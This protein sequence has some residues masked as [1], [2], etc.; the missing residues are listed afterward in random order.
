MILSSYLLGIK[1]F[2]IDVLLSRI[3]LNLEFPKNFKKHT[4]KQKFIS[5]WIQSQKRELHFKVPGVYDIQFSK[6]GQYLTIVFK[7]HFKIYNT[8]TWKLEKT[9]CHNSRIFKVFMKSSTDYKFIDIYGRTHNCGYRFNLSLEN[10]ECI[11]HPDKTMFVVAD[12]NHF[13]VYS[14]KT[15]FITRKIIKSRSPK[16]FFSPC[17]SWFFCTALFSPTRMYSTTTWEDWQI[18]EKHIQEDSE[19]SESSVL[20][21]STRRNWEY[22]I[23][24]N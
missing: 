3:T 14:H 16:Y 19:I 13:L 23:C 15:G 10:F 4:S 24:Y 21:Y 7:K 1:N 20:Y 22:G 8:Q 12:S 5:I 18:Y 11:E 2:I 9:I 6:N 17:G